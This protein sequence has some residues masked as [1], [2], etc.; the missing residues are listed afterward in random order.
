MATLSTVQPSRQEALADQ[1]PA[2]LR[3]LARLA[4]NYWWSWQPEGEALWRSVDAE[5]WDA[6][7][8]NPVRLLRELPRRAL[9]DAAASGTLRER[10]VL[11]SGGLDAELARPVTPTPPASADAPIAFLCAEFAVHPSLPIYAGGLGVLAGDLLKEA[12]DRALPLVAVGL[13]YRRGYFHQRLDPSGWQHEYWTDTS[14]ERLPLEHVVDGG[15]APLVIGIPVR[16]GTVRAAVYRA[17]V[18]RVPLFLLDTDLPENEPVDRFITAQLYVGDRA[19]RLMQYVVLGLGA[20]RALAAAG[21]QPALYHL[22]EG[23]P[24]LATLELA[25]PALARG[26]PL[27]AVMEDVRRRVVFTTHTP[28]AAGNEAYPQPELEAVLGA[29]LRE[30]GGHAANVL[31]LGR[32]PEAHPAQPFGMS[33]LALRT[34]CSANAVSRRHGEVA[35]SMWAHH[36]PARRVEEVPIGHVTNGVHLPTWM[37]APMRALLDRHLAPGWAAHPADPWQ[38]AALDAIPDEELWA[39]RNQLRGELV[40]LVRQRSVTD[41]LA[42]GEPLDYVERAAATFDPAVLTLGFARRVASYKR[43]HLLVANAR[44]ALGLLSSEQPVQLV[45]AGKAH[46]LDDGAKRMVQA[47]FSLKG[48]PVAGA[49]VVFLEDYDLDT[50]RVLVAGCDVWVNLPRPPMEASGT[51]GMKA[52]LNGGLNLSVLDGWWAEAWDGENGWAIRSEP[53]LDEA[54]QDQRDADVLYGLLEREVVPLFHERD[55]AGLPRAWIHRVRASIRSLAPAFNTARTLRDYA[56]HVYGR[57]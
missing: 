10:M 38:W 28:V 52:A 3:P 33:D 47:V 2:A 46:P 43:L 17:D 34:S 22:N 25:R 14:P 20:V 31:D 23:H 54:I 5:A 6:C 15:G 4:Y 16:A 56:V 40:A 37:A 32:A 13:L 1:L 48:A 50:A 53:G 42:R 35:R 19:Y 7:G 41:R 12:S 27:D 57:R 44:R 29:F 39:T 30:L 45:I 55:A 49:R 11:L 9:D 8:H 24:A 21:I 26:E 36:W 51:S 18:G